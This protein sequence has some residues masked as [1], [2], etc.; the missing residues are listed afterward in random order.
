MTKLK[1]KVALVTGGGS[2][3]GR[4]ICHRFAKDQADVVVND[5]EMKSVEKVSK[6][7]ESF[8]ARALGI[9]ADVSLKSSV[10]EMVSR[11]IKEWNRIDILVNCAGIARINPLLE[12]TE[13]EFDRVYQVNL[14]G[15]FLCTQIV[16]KEMIKRGG[17][18]II[19][20]SSLAGRRPAEF[21]AAYGATK[22]GVIGLT[23]STA[24]ELSRYGI[25]CNAV[26]PGVI[27]TPLSTLRDKREAEIRG[28]EK[29]DTMARG[30][31]NVPL[32]RAGQPEDVAN[33]VS[34][35]ASSDADYVNGQTINVC[36][37]L[38]FS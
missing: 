2:G 26:A 4:G 7:L 27:D 29:I 16:A 3:I 23:Q 8:G 5:V 37:G 9:C 36:G 11:I 22:F 14:K 38:V 33:V 20:V 28:V 17:G 30:V 32:G 18:R 12:T 13:E 35:L 15:P 31:K 10:E 21:L 24:L 6:E 34:F 25:T 19:N 1:G